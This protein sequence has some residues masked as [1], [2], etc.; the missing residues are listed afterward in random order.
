MAEM[1]QANSDL[2]KHS[3]LTEQENLVMKENINKLLVK[4][5]D[6]NAHMP[7]KIAKKMELEAKL[8]AEQAKALE[9]GDDRK[10]GCCI[11]C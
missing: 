1:V 5:A 10:K 2:T 7:K 9:S 8:A 4:I 3:Q 11:I 6:L